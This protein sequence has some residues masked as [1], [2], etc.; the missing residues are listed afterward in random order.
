MPIYTDSENKAFELLPEGDYRFCVTEFGI[1]ISSSGK[2]NGSEKYTA[3]LE[4]EPSGNT[5]TEFLFDHKSTI[6]KLDCFLKSIGVQLKKDEPYEFKRDVAEEKRRRW[7]NPVYMRGWCRIVQEPYTSKKDNSQKM[8][9]KVAIFYTDK[10]KLPPRPVEA[11][12]AQEAEAFV[13]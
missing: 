2:T 5:V 13:P 7:I 12:A 8:G 1:T 3:K 9:N 4:I 10:E 6:W 11:P